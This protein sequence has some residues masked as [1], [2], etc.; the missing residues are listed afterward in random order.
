MSTAF[1]V[2]KMLNICSVSVSL[3]LPVYAI[4]L[5]ILTAPFR[6]SVVP[7]FVKDCICGYDGQ[8]VCGLSLSGAHVGAKVVNRREFGWS[9]F[10]K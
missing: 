9:R 7:M 3:Q 8:V 10:G 2:H 4:L 1:R 5:I 6:V